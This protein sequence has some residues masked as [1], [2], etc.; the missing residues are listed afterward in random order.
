MFFLPLMLFCKLLLSQKNKIICNS[1]KSVCKVLSP[2]RLISVNVPMFVCSS[3]D[4]EAAYF[5][6]L[7]VMNNYFI[8]VHSISQH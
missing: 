2:Q 4:G 1:D 6:T 7:I 5:L 3:T 8:T